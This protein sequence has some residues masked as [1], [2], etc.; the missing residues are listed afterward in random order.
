MSKTFKIVLVLLV[1]ASI[2]SAVLAV[3]A[4][5]QKEKEYM[6]RVLIEDKMAATLKEKRK[7]EKE[8]E[9]SRKEKQD[10]ETRILDMEARIE[11]F[12]AQIEDMEN[13]NKLAEVDIKVK[14]KKIEELERALEKEKKEKVNVSKQL[15]AVQAD[16]DRSEKEILRLKSERIGLEQKI[17]DLKEKSVD[18]ERI[19]LNP[20][21]GGVGRETA[22]VE[23]VREPL[24]GSVLVVNKDYSFVVTDL[25]KDDG[26]EKEILLEIRDGAKFLGRAKV[27]K[28]YDTMSSASILPGSDINNIKKGN[29]VIESR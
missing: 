23:P 28:V 2:T 24:R 22:P 18:L 26:V 4:F 27:D 1:A 13:E 5:V 29:F 8:I 20:S 10:I 12:T 19:V 6:K 14:E 9:L 25:G 17:A 15:E 3:L 16:Y 11:E 7:L 21:T